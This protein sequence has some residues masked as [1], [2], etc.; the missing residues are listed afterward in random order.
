MTKW[1]LTNYPAREFRHTIEG[2]WLVKD[3]KTGKTD[4]VVFRS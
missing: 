4:C 1:E 2:F 3:K